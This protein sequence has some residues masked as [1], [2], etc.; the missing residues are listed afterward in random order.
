MRQ[1]IVAFD[2]QYLKLGNHKPFL[3]PVV[4]T[5]V[6]GHAPMEVSLVSES[7]QKENLGTYL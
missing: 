4:L 1:S 5:E 3:A 2:F 6:P 7:G